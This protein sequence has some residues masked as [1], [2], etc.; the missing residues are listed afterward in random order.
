MPELT[1]SAE[2]ITAALQRHVSEYTSDVRAEQ[3][4]RIRSILENLSLSVAN[5]AETREMLSLK[6]GANVGF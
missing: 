6:G 3:V 5:P 4:G 1:I 2:D